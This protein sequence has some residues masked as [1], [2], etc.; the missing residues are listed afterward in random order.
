MRGQIIDKVR[1]FTPNLCQTYP[2]KLQNLLLIWLNDKQYVSKTSINFQLLYNWNFTWMNIQDFQ[3][4]LQLKRIMLKILSNFR[5]IQFVPIYHINARLI[6]KKHV[7]Q[8]TIRFRVY[9]L[10]IYY[11]PLYLFCIYQKTILSLDKNK[12][13]ISSTTIWIMKWK[14]KMKSWKPCIAPIYIICYIEQFGTWLYNWFLN[15]SGCN[16]LSEWNA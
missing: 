1:R 7:K 8:K 14:Q 3:T 15:F 9:S 11:H 16:F 12:I 4:R 6:W 13:Q 5:C 10:K 2:I